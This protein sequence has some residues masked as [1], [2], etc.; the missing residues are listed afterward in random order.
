MRQESPDSEITIQD[1]GPDEDV[2][3]S[4]RV[5]NFFRPIQLLVEM[6]GLPPYKAFDPTPFLQ[7]NFFLFFGICFSDVCYGIML[8]TLGT[9][10][11]VKTRAYRGLN[12]FSR[13]LL[14]GGVSS[15]IFGAILGSWFGD[16]YKPDYLGKDN[17]LLRLQ[18]MFV[19]LDPIDKTIVALLCALGIGICN[20]FYGI[21]LKMYGALRNR[22]F[23]GAFSDGVCWIVTLTG[24]LMMV[25]KIFT[26]IPAPLFNTGFW[27]FII[28]AI[29]LV[30]TQGREFKSPFGKLCR[31]PGEPLRH[32]GQ[33]RHHGLHR[34]YA[35]LLPFAGARPDDFDCGHDLQPHCRHAQGCSLRRVHP[36]PDRARGWASV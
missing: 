9:Y 29:G 11:A 25:G 18:E 10:L 32:H 35:L 5:P 27:F 24:L 21:I 30:L 16:L 14:Y 22:D 31:G 15:I 8:T 19:V 36:L 34:R 1:P 2:P 20:Q 28:G 26:D 4:I 12:N 6:F 7:V 3:V 33:L 23:L 13:I 17:F